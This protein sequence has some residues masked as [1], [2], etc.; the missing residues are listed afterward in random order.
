MESLSPFNML[1]TYRYAAGRC[2]VTF[3]TFQLSGEDVCSFL[4]NQSTLDYKSLPQK[5]FNLIS[6]LDPQGRLEFYGWVLKG[7][8][9]CRLLV[10]PVLKTQS[11][12]RLER[13]LIS[14]DVTI[15]DLGDQTWT[16]VLGPQVDRYIEESSF[17]GTL[18]EEPSFV[19]QMP[20]SDVPLV[21]AEDAKRWSELNGW[22]DFGGLH[23]KSE[24]INNNRLF[25]L[26]VSPNKGCYPGQE[27]VSKIA[28]RRGA[29][30]SPVLLESSTSLPL[31]SISNFD[32]KIGEIVTS[33][34]LKNSF[35]ACA[36]ILR[37]FRVEGMKLQFSIEGHEYS[38][39]VRY[40]PLLS[41]SVDEKALELFYEAMEKFKHDQLKEAETDL[42]KA[43]ELNPLYADAYESLGVMLGR[44]ERFKEAIELMDQLTKVDPASVLAH[45]N[46]SLY[47]MR[48]GKIEEAE[49]EKSHATIKSFQ[50]FGEESKNKELAEQQQKQQQAEWQRR[51]QMFRDVLEIDEEDTLANYGLGSIA[52]E[53]MQWQTAIDHL[54]KVLK[55]DDQYSVA[56]LDL[57]KAYKGFGNKEKARSVWQKGVSVAAKKGD[58]MPANQ[59]Q[60]E[61]SQF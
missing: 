25:D 24:L 30:Y 57:G 58:L 46:K 36:H 35:F 42:R 22:P 53:R 43:L 21:S 60:S 23:F 39:V 19:D 20:H 1:D 59:M 56:Y 27:T 5:N 2:A 9:E 28:T 40:Y 31:G 50:K 18:W 41:G 8:T 48:L 44:Q 33:H 7:S 10:P 3:S 61:L 26:S 16:F 47:L 11:L 45:T 38:A 6:F 14:E 12:A 15:E 55:A 49:I 29:A 32:K 34:G 37:D 52:V 13:F 17:S 4:Q 54:E 51:E